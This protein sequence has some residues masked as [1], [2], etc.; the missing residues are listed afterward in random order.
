MQ[1]EWGNQV[2]LLF[3]SQELRIRHRED[4]DQSDAGIPDGK[5]KRAR[6]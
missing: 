3:S 5:K 1:P 2:V 4:P 6:T